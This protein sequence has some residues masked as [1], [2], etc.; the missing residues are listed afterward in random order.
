MERPTVTTVTLV[1]SNSCPD[2]VQLVNSQRANRMGD[3][4]DLVELA[5]VVQKGNEFI[6]ANATNKLTI[7]AEQIR[8]LQEQAHKA[9]E[10]AKKDADLHHA[11][12]NIVK[13]PGTTYHMYLR[14]S[15]QKYLSILSPEEWGASCPHEHLGSWRLE[16]DMSWTPLADVQKKSEH[17]AL[18][19]KVLNSQLAITDTV[20]RKS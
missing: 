1:E 8:F 17:L 10:E 2:G 14:E 6:R 16:Y 20:N 12:C 9:L 18:M 7:I 13:K 11:A 3:P 5:L 15:G 19:D 4:N